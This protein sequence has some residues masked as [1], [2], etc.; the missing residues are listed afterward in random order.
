VFRLISE[1]FRKAS[2]FPRLLEERPGKRRIMRGLTSQEEGNKLLASPITEVR[3]QTRQG[4]DT[5][6]SMMR[7]SMTGHVTD[8]G[9]PQR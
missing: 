3:A 2:E 4:D 5:G 8:Q 6:F 1:M 9:G 7:F